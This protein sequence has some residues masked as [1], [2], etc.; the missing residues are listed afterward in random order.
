MALPYSNEDS[1]TRFMCT[2]CLFRHEMTE[3]ELQ[4]EVARIKNSPCGCYPQIVA[5]DYIMLSESGEWLAHHNNV[6]MVRGEIC[7][8][9][10]A[11]IVCRK[12][13]FHDR[14]CREESR[15]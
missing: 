11:P 4:G 9:S 2:F 8:Q 3:K 15:I 12:S 7:I 6:R 1:P 10:N 13:L 14:D 5:S